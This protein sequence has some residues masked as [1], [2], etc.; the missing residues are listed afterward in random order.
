MSYMERKGPH[1]GVFSDYPAKGKIQA[2]GLHGRVKLML[3]ATDR[4]K[5]AF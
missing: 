2:L 4:E 1:I 5:N 3:C